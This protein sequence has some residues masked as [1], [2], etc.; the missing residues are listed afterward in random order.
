[1]VASPSPVLDLVDEVP[2]A[3]T[4]TGTDLA[5]FVDELAAY[6]ASYAPYF[7]PDQRGWA[8]FYLRGL[9]TADVPRK[10]IEAMVL[11]LLGAGPAADRQ[12]RAAQYF[13]SEGKWDDAAVLAA[14][15]RLVG[16]TLGE[17][18]GVL[19]LDGS[20]VPKQ[21]RHSVG[22]AR[23][24]CGATGKRDNCQAG[25]YLAYASGGGYTLVDRRLYL[26]AAWF[27]AA[28]TERRR[29]C[30]IP[31]TVEFATKAQLAADMVEELR[32]RE[33]L[34]A[35]WLTADEAF[36]E[37]PA[38]LDRVAACDL[39]YLAEVP[40]TTPVWPLVDPASGQ[41]CPRP[42]RWVPPQKASRKGPVPRRAQLHPAS[43]PKE[44]VAAVAT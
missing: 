5:D 21:G 41:P 27:D 35:R 12:V 19:I 17:A 42:Q 10:N 2:V 3:R 13:I 34:S 14:H 9:L 36:G 32:T 30:A 43:P 40:R 6:Q 31:A 38:V 16:E 15:Q 7:R 22:V 39:W 37:D 26:P 1:M 23:Q 44:T 33:R 8:A 24:Y 11:R 25:V 29:A 18:D 4:V 20:D 28:H